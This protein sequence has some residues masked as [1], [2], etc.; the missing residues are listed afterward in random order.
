MVCY[1]LEQSLI[2]GF[3]VHTFGHEKYLKSLL[4]SSP[5]LLT[6]SG[7]CILKRESTVKSCPMNFR[8]HCY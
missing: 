2:Q 6:A 7:N 4:R 5:F 3:R 1:E 8:S